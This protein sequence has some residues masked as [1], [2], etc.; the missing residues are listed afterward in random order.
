MSPVSGMMR[1]PCLL[2][3]LPGLRSR[4]TASLT[5][6]MSSGTSMA[7]ANSP[8]RLGLLGLPSAGVATSNGSGTFRP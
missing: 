4:P 6:L 5:W 8:G 7:P 3:T 1:S 2:A